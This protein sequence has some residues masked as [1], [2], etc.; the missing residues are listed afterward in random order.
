MMEAA[1][2]KGFNTVVRN[3]IRIGL[4]DV[5]N[6][7]VISRIEMRRNDSMILVRYPKILEVNLYRVEDKTI[8]PATCPLWRPN[9]TWFWAGRI[10]A[11]N[12]VVVVEM[13]HPP[14]PL[15]LTVW[16]HDRVLPS[17]VQTRSAIWPQPASPKEDDDV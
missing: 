16:Y 4:K 9:E 15:L 8:Y 14:G 3:G 7:C 1:L 12:S 13:E 10:Y 2:S 6:S 17:P 5:G 11:K